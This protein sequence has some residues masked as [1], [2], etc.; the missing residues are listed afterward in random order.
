MKRLFAFV[1]VFSFLLV[2]CT[3]PYM[4]SPPQ[5]P[6]ETPRPKVSLEIINKETH[7]AQTTDYIIA[8]A[9]LYNKGD[10]TVY[11]VKVKVEMLDENKN[12]IDTEWTYAVGG[13]GIK[14]GAKA[15]FDMMFEN[16]EGT[17]SR[18]ISVMDFDY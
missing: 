4:E 8:E 13:E 17:E 2:G 12:V 9:D 10:V 11:F 3:V 18:T 1:S 6:S 16:L 15:H 7:Y 5:T 14:P